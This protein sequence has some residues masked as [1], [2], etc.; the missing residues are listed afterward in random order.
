MPVTHGVAGSSPVH[1]AKTYNFI[2]KASQESGN[3]CF[4]S[5]KECGR[6][7]EMSKSIVKKFVVLM[8]Q[9]KIDS[10]EISI[11]FANLKMNEKW[12]YRKLTKLYKKY[13]KYFYR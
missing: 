4:K 10:N 9:R 7:S 1:T 13:S 6:Y 12:N 3:K 5:F 2:G 8:E 11:C